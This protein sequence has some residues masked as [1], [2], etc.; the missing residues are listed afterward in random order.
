MT[1]KGRRNVDNIH[2][3]VFPLPIRKAKKNIEAVE[4]SKFGVG[5][6]KRDED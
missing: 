1:T 2:K 4:N 5:H 3:G 6:L